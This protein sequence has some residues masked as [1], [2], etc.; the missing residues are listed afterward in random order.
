MEN[1]KEG[2]E[3]ALESLNIRSESRKIILKEEQEK[4]VIELLSGNDVLAILPTGFGKSMIYTIFALA[5]Q[6]MTS[7]GSGSLA[8]QKPD[9]GP[10]IRNGV[11]GLHGC[12][13]EERQCQD[14]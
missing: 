6:N 10:D 3:K 4:A 13:T 12:W 7:T 9:R 8:T 14:C 5:S 2:I 11:T 1:A